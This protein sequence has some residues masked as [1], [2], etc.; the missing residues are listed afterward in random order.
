MLYQLSYFRKIDAHCSDAHCSNCHLA[1]VRYVQLSWGKV[2]LYQLSYFRKN[3]KN[4]T[5]KI[6]K[7]FI[8]QKLF[9]KFKILCFC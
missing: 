1:K 3:I 5:A 2:M 6:L 9:E 8:P 4:A 7:I